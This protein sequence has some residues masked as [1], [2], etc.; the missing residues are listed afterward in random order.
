MAQIKTPK[1]RALASFWHSHHGP[2]VA[3][4]LTEFSPSIATADSTHFQMGNHYRRR[5]SAMF[6]LLDGFA[7][8]SRGSKV[9]G[10]HH[11]VDHGEGLFCQHTVLVPDLKNPGARHDLPILRGTITAT[12]T[13]GIVRDTA[14]G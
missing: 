8:R 6:G 14:M 3:C 5:S 12:W 13:V 2:Q 9:T 11:Q 7:G 10:V 4:P 1:T